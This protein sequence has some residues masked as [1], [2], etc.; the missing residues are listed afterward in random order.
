MSTKSQ[1]RRRSIEMPT[2]AG[3][4]Q[5]AGP[6]LV[7]LL[8]VSISV[9]SLF[10]DA[11]SPEH[12]THLVNGIERIEDDGTVIYTEHARRIMAD[13]NPILTEPL[14]PSRAKERFPRLLETLTAH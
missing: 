12:R 9:A 13:I 2:P 4:R 11:K 10:Y 3:L 8:A 6:A 1:R 5:I 14:V 7:P